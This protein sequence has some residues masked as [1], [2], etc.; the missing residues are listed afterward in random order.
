ME[1]CR[2]TSGEDLNLWNIVG[3]QFDKAAATL[4]VPRGLLDQI[5]ACNAVYYMQFPVRIGDLFDFPYREVWS[6]L[7][8]MVEH[9]G[10]DRLLWGTDFGFGF[11]DSL[12]YRLNLIYRAR[13]D[14]ALREQI[15]GV[16]PLRLFEA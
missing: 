3:R 5:K 10:P 4:D 12:A 6:A 11:T 13:I 7:K 2:K 14:D 1:K 8:A 15:L 16:N 9:I